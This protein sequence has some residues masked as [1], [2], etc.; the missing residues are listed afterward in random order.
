M[1]DDIYFAPACLINWLDKRYRVLQLFIKGWTLMTI[2]DL[3]YR[4]QNGSHKTAN[5][6]IDFI[7]SWSMKIAFDDIKSVINI[8]KSYS[9]LICTTKQRNNNVSPT[10]FIMEY[11]FIICADNRMIVDNQH[12]AVCDYCSVWWC[13]CWQT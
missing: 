4:T 2:Y 9:S 10:L 12:I 7:S 5:R 13:V 11:L 8:W 3:L 1:P 6:S